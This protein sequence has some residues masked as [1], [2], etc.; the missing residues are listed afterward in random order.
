MLDPNAL[1]QL[2]QQEIQT[3]VQQEVD[4][5]VK[6]TDWIAELER[7]IITHV[8]DRITA[9]FSNI[10]TL[11][12][13]VGTV[14]KSVETLFERGFVPDISEFVKPKSVQKSVDIAVENFVT[15]TLNNLTVDPQWIDKIQNLV[16]QTMVDKLKQSINSV[17]VNQT[18]TDIVLDNR[19]TLV[20]TFKEDFSTVGIKDQSN[21]LQLTVMDGAVVVEHELYTTDLNVENNT[22]LKGDLLV[23]GDLAIKG[24]VN[25]DN[26]SWQEL[27]DNIGEKTYTRVKRDFEDH[28]VDSVFNRAKQ[29]FEFENV[30][31][32]GEH[33]V[34]DGTLASSITKSNL[35]QV[36]KLKNLSVQGRIGINTESPTDALCVWDEEVSIVAG[37]HSENTGYIGTVKNQD[38]VI[39]TN[40]Q[41]QI[42]V[43]KD[44]G[45][46]VDKLTVGKN[47]IAH[48]RSVP[49]YA[50]TKGDIVFNIDMKPDS[51]FAW[52]CLGNYRWQELRSA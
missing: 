38:L 8:Q 37:K 12:D 5:I 16:N 22:H 4:A 43:N 24:R 49:N 35:T 21:H 39:G 18:L 19:D 10:A 46:K 15:D 31:V 42:V 51:P 17:D 25:I 33:L 6:Q 41:R 2:V 7:Q 50:G 20:N 27:A 40:R 28:V 30:I 52:I 11:P 45:V 34:A 29:G 9:R 1:S 3:S 36:G 44:G 23:N 47:N 48:E 32:N 26:A 14:E 13:L